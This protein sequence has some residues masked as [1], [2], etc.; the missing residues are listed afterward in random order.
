MQNV[1]TALWHKENKKT[2]E[3]V[4]SKTENLIFCTI[5]LFTARVAPELFLMRFIILREVFL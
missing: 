1:K 2:K 3:E 4:V 5:T